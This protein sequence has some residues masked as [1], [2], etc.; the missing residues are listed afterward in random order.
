MTDE[1]VKSLEIRACRDADRAAVCE[2]WRNVFDDAPAWN[3]PE[4]DIELKQTAQPELLLVALTDG[5]LVGTVMA[6]FDGHRGWIHLLAVDPAHRRAGIADALVR[7]AETGLQK[8]GCRKVNLQVRAGN[9]QVM[10][11]YEKLG[12]GVEERVSMGKRIGSG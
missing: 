12:Y 7:A 3:V 10:S 11:F 8:L 9:E 6:G 1:N 4:D 5:V 2:L